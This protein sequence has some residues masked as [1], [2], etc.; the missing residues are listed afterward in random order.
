MVFL[1]K[2]HRMSELVVTVW[3]MSVYVCFYFHLCFVSSLK[4]FLENNINYFGVRFSSANW[5]VL[6]CRLL[7]YICFYSFR[8]CALIVWSAYVGIGI[9]G[10]YSVKTDVMLFVSVLILK[11][12]HKKIQKCLSIQKISP[13]SFVLNSYVLYEFK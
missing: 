6:E 13:V 1:S 5:K 8:Y 9:V 7:K 2:Q 3:C 12:F 10:K 4:S 11:N